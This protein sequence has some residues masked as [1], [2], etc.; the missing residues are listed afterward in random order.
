MK[1]FAEVAGWKLGHPAGLRTFLDKRDAER[2][3]KGVKLHQVGEV[4]VL[5]PA[6]LGRFPT[7]AAL[8]VWAQEYAAANGRPA[9]KRASAKKK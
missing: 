9:P 7:P 2:R 5:W 8:E 6:G 4:F 3:A 1:N